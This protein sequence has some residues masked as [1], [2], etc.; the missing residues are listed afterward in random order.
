MLRS[1]AR[2]LAVHLLYGVEFTGDEPEQVIDTRLDREYY[3]KLAEEN[4][5]YTER[6]SKK[7]LAYIDTVVSGAA[8]RQEEL[9]SVIASFSIGWDVRRISRWARA[10]MQLAIFEAK[11]MD[12][13]P[14]GVAI[15]EAVRIIKKYDADAASF[16]NGIL[17]SFARSLKAEETAPQMAQKA[18]SG[19]PEAGEAGAPV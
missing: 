4:P 3:K 18:A 12:E 5:I 1:D 2:E 11:Y 13:I 17:G 8:N 14:V 9:N 10:T 7:Q 19:E 16:A 15:S 6:P